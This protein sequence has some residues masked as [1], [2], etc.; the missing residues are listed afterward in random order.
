MQAS[1]ISIKKKQSE[2]KACEN[3]ISPKIQFF[4]VFRL[5]IGKILKEIQIE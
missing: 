2:M 1:S 3:N 4:A 5:E